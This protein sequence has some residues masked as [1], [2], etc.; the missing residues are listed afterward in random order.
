[1]IVC[2]P[3]ENYH[4]CWAFLLLLTMEKSIIERRS[5]VSAQCLRTGPPPRWTNSQ[6][7][8]KQEMPAPP[9]YKWRASH[10]ESRRRDPHQPKR[11]PKSCMLRSRQTLQASVGTLCWQMVSQL[12]FRDRV[13]LF[14][15]ILSL[16]LSFCIAFLNQ[17]TEEVAGYLGNIHLLFPTMS[18][19][20]G[21]REEME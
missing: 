8:R 13:D 12:F 14:R 18:A 5:N 20:W 15:Q 2:P 21:L 19:L 16:F 10:K 7:L 17:G 9:G 6:R 3:Y 4:L 1:M 11:Q